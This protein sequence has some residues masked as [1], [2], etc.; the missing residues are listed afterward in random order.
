VFGD[1]QEI[2]GSGVFSLLVLLI[3]RR[4]F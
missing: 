1:E 3:A 2:Q 4:V